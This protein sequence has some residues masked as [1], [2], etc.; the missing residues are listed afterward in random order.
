MRRLSASRENLQA[1]DRVM[2][3]W[4]RVL[5][6]LLYM[7]EQIDQL[8]ATESAAEDEDRE[9]ERAAA[10]MQLKMA[11]VSANVGDFTNPHLLDS[12]EPFGHKALTLQY[13][14]WQHEL[15]IGLDK[16]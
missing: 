3:D 5:P 14:E 10:R 8:M 13:L 2:A 15:V 7:R 4:P 11:I 6:F 16:V 9:Q 1:L 12:E